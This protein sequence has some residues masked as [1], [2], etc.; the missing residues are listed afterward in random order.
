MNIVQKGKEIAL[1]EKKSM[2]VSAA[3]FYTTENIAFD[4]LIIGA[5]KL[6]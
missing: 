6:I 1:Y 4:E 3:V 5:I 2:V